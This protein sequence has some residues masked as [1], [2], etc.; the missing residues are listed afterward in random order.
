MPK[1]RCM[2]AM[3]GDRCLDPT[4]RIITCGA[5]AFNGHRQLSALH[6]ASCST[7]AVRWSFLMLFHQP[8]TTRRPRVPKVLRFPCERRM[9]DDISASATTCSGELFSLSASLQISA[10]LALS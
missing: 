8:P 4:P 5:P 2:I 7:Y 10:D 6:H 3:D 1:R 9:G